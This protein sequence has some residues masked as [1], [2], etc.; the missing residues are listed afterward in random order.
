M[1]PR[2]ARSLILAAVFAAALTTMIP[3]APTCAQQN[4]RIGTFDSRVVALIIFRSPE[5]MEMMKDLHTR[6]SAADENK[7]TKEVARLER[8]G[9]LRQAMMHELVFGNGSVNDMIDLLK[10]PVAEI[11]KKE[12]LAA[13]VSKWEL[14]FQSPDIEYVDITMQLA[15]SLKVDAKTKKMIPEVMLQEPLKEAYL[16]ED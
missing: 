7:D 4:I 16:I 1:Y 8:E 12:H 5:T 6:R 9:Q 3:S 13:V 10:Q 11:A 2:H 15:E 14:Y